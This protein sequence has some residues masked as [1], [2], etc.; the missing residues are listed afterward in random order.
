[1]AK[2]LS[3]TLW[4]PLHVPIV[5]WDAFLTPKVLSNVV[6]VL[7]A[8][9]HLQLDL[10]AVMLVPVDDLLLLDNVKIVQQDDSIRLLDQPIVKQLQ[11]E[12][13]FQFLDNPSLL[14]VNEVSFKMFQGNCRASHVQMERQQLYEVQ[15]NVLHVYLVCLVIK[16]D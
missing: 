1:M 7:S 9:W 4:D 12:H 2:V 14:C 11:L 5:H 16:Q 3:L 13:T 15:N 6:N 8:K 10:E